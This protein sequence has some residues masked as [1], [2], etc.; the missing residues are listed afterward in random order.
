MKPRSKD[1]RP[2]SLRQGRY[3]LFA[4]LGSGSTAMLYLAA[5]E[6]A[7]GFEKIH[8]LKCLKRDLVEEPEFLTMFVDEARLAARLEH[9]NVVRTVEVCVSDGQ[10]SIVME[11]VEGCSLHQLLH[12]SR[13]GA[14]R[15]EAAHWIA[16][17]IGVL[18][19]LDYAHNLADFDGTPLGVVHRDVSPGNVLISCAGEVKLTDFGIAKAALRSG[20]TAVGTIKGK[21]QYMS[22]E[23]IRGDAVDARADI[24]AVGVLLWELVA[25]RAPWR[26]PNP[27][28]RV[29]TER[30]SEVVSDVDPD[31]DSICERALANDRSVRYQTADEMLRALEDY[32]ARHG[33]RVNRLELGRLVRSAAGAELDQ[34]QAIV[35]DQLAKLRDARSGND[36][37]LTQL[38]GVLESIPP[39]P[40]SV[41]LRPTRRARSSRKGWVYVVLLIAMAGAGSALLFLHQRGQLFPVP[42]QASAPSTSVMDSTAPPAASAGEIEIYIVATPPEAA[43]YID[44]QRMPANPHRGHVPKDSVTHRVRVEA[45][46]HVPVERVLTYQDDVVIRLRLELMPV[47]T[48]VPK[49][50]ALPTASPWDP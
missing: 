26:T 37:P 20:T 50:T 45:P 27:K 22:P 5:A 29:L 43:I 32:V 31:L 23:Q 39:E 4:E 12:A 35:R 14:V 6:S 48:S 44:G 13:S 47:K 3:C 24:F 2:I 21:M 18:T 46:Q 30:L 38:P 7:L 15:V 34:R 36:W 10:P 19:G 17:V 16:I 1:P 42:S 33:R 9:P 49:P 8:A 25:G 28:K 40:T 11:Y 41:S